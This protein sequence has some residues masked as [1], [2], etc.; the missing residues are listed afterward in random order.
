MYAV[1]TV[2]AS[3]GRGMLRGRKSLVTAAAVLLLTVCLVAVTLRARPVPLLSEGGVPLD[4]GVPEMQVAPVVACPPVLVQGVLRQPSVSGAAAAA[5][6]ATVYVITPTY[7]RA[8]QVPEMT[9]LAQTLM[10]ASN[11]FWVV[12]EDASERTPAVTEILQ[13]S[14]VPH[15]HILG[16][17]PA[18]RRA[19]VQA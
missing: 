7:P 6:L 10:H 19:A 5:G 9:R 4:A 16:E 15:V 18:G 11:V 12:T 1:L 17:W 3:A 14:G 8:V 2:W 13:G